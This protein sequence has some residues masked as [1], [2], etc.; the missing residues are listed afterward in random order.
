M[1]SRKGV[2]IRKST[3][4]STSRSS[5]SDQSMNASLPKSF[6]VDIKHNERQERKKHNKQ[7]HQRQQTLEKQKVR[8]HSTSLGVQEQSANNLSSIHEM[9]V[10]DGGPRKKVKLSLPNE[11][12][13]KKIDDFWDCQK[14]SFEDKL[15]ETTDNI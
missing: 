15:E 8:K 6:P 7:K 9:R 4:R 11:Q 12:V 5:S 3:K 13:P 14:D 1:D 2:A 10:L